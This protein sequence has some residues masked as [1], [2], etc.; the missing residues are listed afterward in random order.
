MKSFKKY[1]KLR[2]SDNIGDPSASPD[3]H[4]ETLKRIIKMAWDRYE[5]ETKDFFGQLANKDPDIKEQFEKL[6]KSPEITKAD[7]LGQ[8]ER[9]AGNGEVIVPSLADTS[10]EEE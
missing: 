10:I 8:S 7:R 3:E 2:E 5:P 6:D 9:R 4:D 1:L